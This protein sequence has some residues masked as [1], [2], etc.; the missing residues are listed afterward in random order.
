[1]D[2]GSPEFA[3]AF[4][5]LPGSY[6]RWIDGWLIDRAIWPEPEAEEDIAPT[7]EMTQDE[8]NE[9][10]NDYERKRWENYDG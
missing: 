7:Q 5:R 1:M 10:M 2:D 8:Y 9:M 3:R 4:R 6:A